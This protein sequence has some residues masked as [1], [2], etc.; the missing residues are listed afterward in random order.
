MSEGGRTGLAPL[1]A[2]LPL[3]ALLATGDLALLLLLERGAR[4]RKAPTGSRRRAWRPLAFQVRSE[5]QPCGPMKSLSM[6][7][8]ILSVTL[9]R[10]DRR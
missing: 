8:A 1:G 9:F 4:G 5:H 7:R 10:P 2:V 6:S 3:L